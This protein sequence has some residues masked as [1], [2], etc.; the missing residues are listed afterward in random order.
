MLPLPEPLRLGV[1]SAAAQCLASVCAEEGQLTSCAA[2]PCSW[3]ALPHMMMMLMPPCGRSRSASGVLLAALQKP[4]VGACWPGRLGDNVP[5]SPCRRPP[6][7]RFQLGM[8]RA[9]GHRLLSAYG[10]SSVPSSEAAGRAAEAG[11][12]LLTHCC[13]RGQDSWV[14]PF[15]CL[16]PSTPC[17]FNAQA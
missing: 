8:T 16:L 1:A 3:L 10:V 13:C 6:P 11:S 7:C 4:W 15:P 5:R 17:S 12:L 14:V 2:A 9:L